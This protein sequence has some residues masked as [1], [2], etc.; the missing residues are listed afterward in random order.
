MEICQSYKN[1]KMIDG[2]W[3]INDTYIVKKDHILYSG[4]WKDVDHPPQHLAQLSDLQVFHFGSLLDEIPHL[5]T[6][7]PKYVTKASSL[8]DQLHRE[9]EIC[10]FL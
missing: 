1:V 10:E 9:V 2:R 6:S 4:T 5:K 7:N 8:E 3:Q